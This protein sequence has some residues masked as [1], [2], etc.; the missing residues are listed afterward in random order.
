MQFGFEEES[1][2]PIKPTVKQEVYKRAKECCEC[3]GI[4]LAKVHGD[5]HH[6]RSPTISPTAKTVQFLCPTCHRK[7]GHTRKVV[8]HYSFL[9]DEKEIVIIRHKV[10]RRKKKATKKK[11]T[12]KRKIR[13]RKTTK[14][15]TKKKT[16]KK[17]PTKK[18]KRKLK[19]TSKRKKPT[20]KRKTSKRKKKKKSPKKKTKSKRRKKG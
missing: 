8:T 7:Y 16:P 18:P 14:K 6:W 4:P 1:R 20:A 9:G 19:K 11:P 10:R 5:F 12:A 13:K 3:C 15:K 17:K 2:K